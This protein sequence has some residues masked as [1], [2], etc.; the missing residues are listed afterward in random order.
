[1]RPSPQ[2]CCLQTKAVLL[3][4]PS[5]PGPLVR[6]SQWSRVLLARVR[7]LVLVEAS[8]WLKDD[9]DSA[10]LRQ[11]LNEITGSALVRPP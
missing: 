5:P 9:D 10:R 3:S 4:P 1:M 8:L 6:W 7:E 2:D 11:G